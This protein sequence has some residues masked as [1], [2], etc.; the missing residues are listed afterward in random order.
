MIVAVSVRDVELLAGLRNAPKRMLYAAANA[1]NNTAKEIQRVE[2]EAATRTFTL[3]GSREFLLRQVAYIGREDFASA[4][5]ARLQARVSVRP[6]PGLLL[7]EYEAGFERKPRVGRHVAVPVEARAT[8]RSDVAPELFIRRLGLRRVGRKAGGVSI[9]GRTGTY[10]VPEVGIFQRVSSFATR[11]LYAF[12]D[13]FR[14]PPKLGWIVR[15]RGV[16]D[17]MFAAELRRQVYESLRFN[18][19]RA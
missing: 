1:I 14:V 8:P 19:R 18:R 5:R 15:A 3:R 10:V 2:R 6:R 13:P 4:P 11:L 12:S 7:P 17:R 16:V 9:R